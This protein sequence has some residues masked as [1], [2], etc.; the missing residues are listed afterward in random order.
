[1]L[2][3][4]N[5]HADAGGYSPTSHQNA[6]DVQAASPNRWV[7]LAALALLAVLGVIGYMR[8]SRPVAAPV[9]GQQVRVGR[10]TIA[11]TVSTSGTTVS[12]RQVKLNFAAGGKIKEVFVKLG[13]R[14]TVGQPIAALDTAPFQL[15][16]ENAESS[17]R[18]AQIKVQ[19]LRDG[20]T[21]EEIAAVAGLLR[22]GADASSRRSP[23]A[24]RPSTSRRLARRWTRPSR[25]RPRP[26]RSS[27][28]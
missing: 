28:R 12:T 27:T 7:W 2:S 14:L 3:K 24:R 5:A 19:Q 25:T 13:D 20:A 1:M 6:P 8:W 10:G 11:Q 18:Q 26:R 23:T 17:V 9:T 22:G 4:V 15:K 16:V 21:P